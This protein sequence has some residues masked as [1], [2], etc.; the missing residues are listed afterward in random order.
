M[1]AGCLF[2]ASGARAAD[3][4]GYAELAASHDRTRIEDSSGATSD[5]TSD[6]FLQRYSVDFTWRLYPNLQMMA[7]G[8][9]EREFTDASLEDVDFETLQRK[10]RPYFNTTLHTPTETASLGW[11]RNEDTFSSGGASLGVVEE[12]LN[13]TFGWMPERFPRTTL[14]FQRT[15][16]Y[17]LERQVQ[18][19]TSDLLDLVAEDQV[20]D[21]LHF[22][23]R[24]AL[25]EI[26]DRV[27]DFE[28]RRVSHAG[29]IDYGDAWWDQRL[30]VGGEYNVH[31]T[32]QELTS[33]GG[34]E[35]VAPLFPIGGLSGIDD[36]PFDG[37]L[38]S[39]PA[40]IDADLTAGV[41]I[42][43]GLPP[44]G[45]DVR[46][47]NLGLDFGAATR[48]NTLFVWVDRDLPAA[49]SASFSW[50]L[51]TS[52]DNVTWQLQ[53]TV[54]PAVFGPF[55]TRFEVRFSVVEARYVKL[56]VD[57]LAAS[58]PN[59]SQFPN[60]FVTEVQAAVRTSAAEATGRSELT[61]QL[62]TTS[63]RARLTDRPILTYEFAAFGRKVDGLPVYG[64]L[65]N[66]FSLRHV[67]NPVYSTTARVAREDSHESDGDR[68]TYLYSASMRAVP[69]P[70]LE[71]TLVFSG[72][73]S[74]RE[75]IPS[76]SSSVR[77][78]TQAE[79][80]RGVNARLGL[81]RSVVLVE[82]GERTDLRDIDVLTTLVPHPAM[83]LSLLFQDETG[84]REGGTLLEEMPVGRQAEEAG[85]TFRPF[86]TLYLF[87]SYRRDTEESLPSRFTR[88]WSA[89]WAP[90]PDGSLQILVRFDDTYRSDLE[91]ESRIF[92]P[93]VRWNVTDRWYL[94]AAYES[95][96]FDS[97]LDARSSDVVTFSTRIWF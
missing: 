90:F 80:Y 92:S 93:R 86:A 51:Y 22:Y 13:A 43:L 24:G 40:M 15:H 26:D 83:S 72:R 25:E 21:S 4:S 9:Y 7:G 87:F 84:T 18:D 48:V 38:T 6:S 36:T 63:L 68:V 53:Q 19:T 30:Q 85:V 88:S 17:D 35:V 1:A 58:V 37:S 96:E 71:S 3:V 45:G 97:A 75:G 10:T 89:S 54:F 8:L 91:A 47:R 31:T 29:R 34:G 16:D 33:S 82:S 77:W 79:I 81:G 20:I 12:I 27:N 59:A 76:D 67:F 41:G 39:N 73:S 70:T 69:L 61:T 14:R 74:E 64:T 49:V 60:I 65:S 11:Y 62:L 46:P 23:Y 28:L 44:I 56:V 55:A 5:L 50:D 94:E 66:G 32:S 78:T 57:P 42:N 2:P 52:P 95:S